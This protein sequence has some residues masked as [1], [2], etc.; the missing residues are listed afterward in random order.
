MSRPLIVVALVS[1]LT[2][3]SADASQASR[4]ASEVT[5]TSAA[6]TVPESVSN[7]VPIIEAGVVPPVIS[8][9]GDFS[10]VPPLSVDT[11]VVT[12]RL[13][14]CLQDQ[15]FAVRVI[16]PGDGLSYE[17]VPPE[18]N[19]LAVKTE[20]ACRAGLGVREMTVADYTDAVRNLFYDYQVALRDCLISEG[21]EIPEP[22]SREYYVEHFFNDPWIPYSWVGLHRSEE[23]E[24]KCPQYPPGGILSWNPDS[25]VPTLPAPPD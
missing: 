7:S 15:G 18:Q 14:A 19:Q 4:P 8:G 20:E 17:D 23:I 2:G 1:L 16:P 3:C 12:M 25:P 5:T 22:P 11:Y 6:E 24:L 10:R 9:Y 13:A 21:F